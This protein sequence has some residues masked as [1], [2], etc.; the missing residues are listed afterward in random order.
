MPKVYRQDTSPL[1]KV[2]FTPQGFAKIEGR[3]TRTGVL[4]YRH[5]DGTITRELRHPDDVFRDDSLSSL[6]GAPVTDLHPKA[7]VNSRNV[8]QLGAGHVAEG[9]V[10]RDGQFVEGTLTVTRQDLIDKVRG[11]DR[12]ELSCGY[13]CDDVIREDGEFEGVAYDHRQVGITYNHVAVGPVG[14]GRA[15][16][17]VALRVDSSD[18]DTQLPG[19]VARLDQQETKT[20]KIRIDGVDFE[21]EN[22]T[23]AQAVQ[24]AMKT[25]DDNL[26]S[27]TG[28]RDAVKAKLDGVTKELDET[29]AKLDTATDPK[30]VQ[31]RIDARVSLQSQAAPI[32]GKEHKFDDQTDRQIREA[33]LSK[34]APAVKCDGQS[35][36][37]VAAAYSTAVSMHKPADGQTPNN[38]QTVQSQLNNGRAD[39]SEDEATEKARQDAHAAGRDAWKQPLRTSLDSTPAA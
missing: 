33:V 27:V 39:G 5:A 4:T 29:K 32:L 28:E 18:G 31:A 37:Y 1:S 22:E 11:G 30:T 15:G 7:L 10:R 36:D 14:W 6:G 2:S 26:A 3:L 23:T 20:M 8:Q 17:E 21:F 16:S 25:R 12:R 9:S 34:I 35:D 13:T 38:S 24:N 19:A